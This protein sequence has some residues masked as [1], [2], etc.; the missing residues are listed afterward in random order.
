MKSSGA[1]IHGAHPWAPPLRGRRFAP[2]ALRSCSGLMRLI[3]L[4]LMAR[5]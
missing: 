3:Q 2:V 1:G 4:E 5:I